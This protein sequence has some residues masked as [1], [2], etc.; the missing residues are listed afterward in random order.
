MELKDILLKKEELPIKHNTHFFIPIHPRLLDSSIR[1]DPKLANNVFP[2]A[3]NDWYEDLKKY[4]EGLEDN[5]TKEWLNNVFLE[6]RPKILKEGRYQ[7]TE[8]LYWE[9]KV[10]VEQNG[11]ARVFSIS[12]NFGGSLYFGGI[13]ECREFV[14]FEG[15]GLIQFPKEKIQEFGHEAYSLGEDGKGVMMEVYRQ[16]NIDSYPGA[17]FLRNWAILYMNEAF[18]QVLD[19]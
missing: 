11:F 19:K 17:L 14:P 15:R 5:E 3:A 1:L 6:Q 4:A 7:R 13:D 8:P 9:D 10:D 2:E 12:R 18:K 16:H